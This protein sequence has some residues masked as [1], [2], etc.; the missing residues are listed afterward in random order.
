MTHRIYYLHGS[1]DSDEPPIQ[2]VLIIL[3][4]IPGG[5][6]ITVHGGEYYVWKWDQ[7]IGMRENGFIIEMKDRGLLYPTV[8]TRHEVFSHGTWLEVDYIGFTEWIEQ[9]RLALIGEM[10]PDE[11]FNELMGKVLA[12]KRYAEEHG[13]LPE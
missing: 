6:W 4:R 9:E 13:E 12:D 1:D 5:N 7:W 8:G 3:Q 2:G 11:V 10:A